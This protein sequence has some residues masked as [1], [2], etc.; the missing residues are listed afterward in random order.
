MV[1]SSFS[2]QIPTLSDKCY[3]Q[4]LEANNSADSSSFYF[5]SDDFYELSPEDYSLAAIK[6]VLSK[7]NCLEGYKEAELQCLKFQS[8]GKTVC[9]ASTNLGYFIVVPDYVD[10]GT[11]IFNRWD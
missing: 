2:A 8:S 9:E 11:L 6:R 3:M 7:F 5:F 4:L 1:L 10:G